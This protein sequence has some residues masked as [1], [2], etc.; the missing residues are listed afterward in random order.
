MLMALQ[1]YLVH[2]CGLLQELEHKL[3]E[4]EYNEETY[5]L[6]VTQAIRVRALFDA[7][8]IARREMT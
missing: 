7:V 5:E 4:E 8:N 6:W 3:A 2:Q 1:H